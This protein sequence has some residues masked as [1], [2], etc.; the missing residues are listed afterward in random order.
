M[1]ITTGMA[2]GQAAQNLTGQGYSQAQM[3]AGA[4]GLYSQQQTQVPYYSEDIAIYVTMVNNGYI[5]A[6]DKT[7]YIAKD[8]DE[9][10][11]YFLS[12]V[13]AMQLDKASNK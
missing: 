6:S 13:T 8:M 1:A 11:T 10:Q 7:K 2:M 5:I 4:S 3:Q 12:L 9:L